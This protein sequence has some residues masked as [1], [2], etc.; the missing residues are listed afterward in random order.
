LL[1]VKNSATIKPIAPKTE[2][3]AVS[4]VEDDLIKEASKYGSAEEFVKNYTL[5]SQLPPQANTFKY[6]KL[7]DIK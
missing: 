3:M 1:P 2:K 5:D 4:N 7:S 6:V